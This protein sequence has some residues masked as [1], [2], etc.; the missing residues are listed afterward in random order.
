MALAEK[1]GKEI[2][3]TPE[4]YASRVRLLALIYFTLNVIALIVA[5]TIAWRVQFFVTISQRSNVETLTI[6][7]IFVLAL[8]YIFTTSK[9]FIGA[10]RMLWLNAS[11]TNKEQRKQ[12]ALKADSQLK[13]VCLDIAVRPAGKPQGEIK[14][15]VEDE[16][17]K[18][19]DLVL[20]G[21]RVTYY[22]VK[23]GM[24]GSLFAF[25]VD[26]IEAILKRQDPHADLQ[27]TQWSAID[28]DGASAY[29]SMAQ[30][31]CNLEQQLG[32]GPVW[33]TVEISE[34]DV[35]EIGGQLRRVVPALRNGSLLPDV[36]YE[37]EYNVPILPE[38][39]G[40]LKLTRHENRADPIVTMGCAGL[41]ML[42]LMLLLTFMILLPPWLPSK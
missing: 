35:K 10:L 33:P 34:D 20:N 19:G 3:R 14:W 8:Y 29:Y 30:A 21:V 4:T 22:P 7:I 27:I 42:S 36:E 6:A 15:E 12:N 40:F 17:G 28:E 25:M 32:K 37:V 23:A 31:F 39:L 18:L 2:V 26:Q 41:I 38:P 9:G 11:P 13:Y 5:V 1:A 24:S 16:A